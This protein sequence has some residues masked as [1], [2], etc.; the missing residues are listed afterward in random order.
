MGKGNRVCDGLFALILPT[1]DGN[2]IRVD[3]LSRIYACF[4]PTYKGWKH[5]MRNQL[6]FE[7]VRALILP[8]RDGNVD[9][10]VVDSKGKQ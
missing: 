6:G 10:I 8:T 5:E 1:R 3:N 4:D 7:E 2:S 9:F